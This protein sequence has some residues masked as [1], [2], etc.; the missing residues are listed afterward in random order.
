MTDQSNV[1]SMA[2][3][4][5][6]FEIASE[7]VGC[8]F[9]ITVTTPPGYAANDA[10]YPGLYVTDG[11]S[12]G[13]QTAQLG[14][15]LM[16]D[17]Q[18][19]LVPYLHVSVGY[20]GGDMLRALVLRNR[21]FI[22]PGEPFPPTIEGY[23]HTLVDMGMMTDADY[24]DFIG[25]VRNGRAD[26]FLAFFEEELHPEIERRFRGAPGAGLFGSSY[27]GLF[28]LYAFAAGS[29]LFDRYGASSPGIIVDDS[30]VF[31]LYEKLAAHEGEPTATHLYMVVNDTE[32]TG[33][34]ELYRHLG[35]GFLRF[36]DLVRKRPLPGLRLT[37]QIVVGEN[38][39]SGIID[40]FRGFVR[41]CYRP[42]SV[43]QVM[44]QPQPLRFLTAGV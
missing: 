13:P 35:M 30:Q 18:Q 40:A 29:R 34:T 16:G 8:T 25:F 5:T 31:A 36:V 28:T 7:R 11:N 17:V 24:A 1:V 42:E 6:Y 3:S 12:L 27:G 41:T 2:P 26:N 33:A 22:P 20:T 4:F 19:P 10:P 9:G 38:H 44:S 37:P 23:I 21:E 43:E 14:L 15:S 32:M 39:G